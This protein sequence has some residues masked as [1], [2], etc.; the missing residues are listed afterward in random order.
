LLQSLYDNIWQEEWMAGGFIW[1]H[2]AE[3][4]RRRGYEKLFTPQGKKA[5][6]TVTEAYRLSL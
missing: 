2:H 3:K 6:V 5:Q 1:K 4:S